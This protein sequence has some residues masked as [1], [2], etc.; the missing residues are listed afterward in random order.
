MA[1]SYEISLSSFSDQKTLW[2]DENATG[3]KKYNSY[4][5]NVQS[6]TSL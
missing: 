4:A 2:N 5:M 3:K 1:S 6:T